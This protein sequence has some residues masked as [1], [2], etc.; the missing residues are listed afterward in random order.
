[1]RADKETLRMDMV[2]EKPTGQETAYNT[3]IN[4]NQ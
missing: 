1:M 3:I 2:V 4:A